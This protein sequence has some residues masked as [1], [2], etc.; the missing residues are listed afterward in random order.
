MALSVTSCIALLATTLLPCT[1]LLSVL[2]V[3][4]CIT[5]QIASEH[6][7]EIAQLEWD[8]GGGGGRR[9]LKGSPL[10]TPS[11]SANGA[12]AGAVWCLV[13]IPDGVGL[14]AEVL[15]K[16]VEEDLCRASGVR[17]AVSQPRSEG[18]QLVMDASIQPPEARSALHSL[19]AQLGDPTSLL[20]W[21]LWL[22]LAWIGP[23]FSIVIGTL[24]PCVAKGCFLG[25]FSW[26]MPSALGFFRGQH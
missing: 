11:S 10:L 26:R 5:L 25:L 1:S 13:R 22:S 19:K 14:S 16:E 23:F 12:P 24:P 20:R 8:L 3:T 15:R 18:G 9:T 4:S 2:S 6:A 17:V 7:R 21:V